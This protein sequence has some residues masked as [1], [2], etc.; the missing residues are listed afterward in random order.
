MC[1]ARLIFPDEN[2]DRQQRLGLLEVGQWVLMDAGKHLAD[3]A[4]FT[5]FLRTCCA[6]FT[7]H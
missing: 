1:D 5:S 6:A 7:T 3:L 2:K 4:V